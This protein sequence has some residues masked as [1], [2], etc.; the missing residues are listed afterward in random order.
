VR[1]IHVESQHASERRAADVAHGE[2]DELPARRGQNALQALELEETLELRPR[3]GDPRLE[4]AVVETVH[5]F[6]VGS[7]DVPQDR[8]HGSED[9]RLRIARSASRLSSRSRRA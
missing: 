2:A 9:Q 6:E 8:F 7:P 5:R 1:G 3:E 4:T